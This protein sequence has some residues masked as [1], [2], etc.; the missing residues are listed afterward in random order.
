MNWSLARLR[1]C[2]CCR[3]CRYHAIVG[4]S[5]MTMET[6][7]EKPLRLAL[8]G[9]SGAGEKFWAKK[10]AATRYPPISWADRI[11][12][13][14]APRLAAGGESGKYRGGSAGGSSDA[15]PSRHAAA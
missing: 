14:L 5:L 8:I 15:R 3:G 11:E 1:C 7:R 2:A 12:Q 10:I 4:N 9:M 13:K 6:N